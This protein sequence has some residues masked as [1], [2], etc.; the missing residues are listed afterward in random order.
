MSTLTCQN[1]GG[2][3]FEK[4]D[5]HYVCRHC[6][7]I[8]RPP[9]TMPHTKL[10]WILILSLVLVAGLFLL[11]RTLHS[12]QD[13]LSHIATAAP[14]QASLPNTT[15]S[16]EKNVTV[17]SDF[18]ALVRSRLGS[19]PIRN[20]IDVYFHSAKLHK[21]FYMAIDPDKRY[22][23]GYAF[24]KSSSKQAQTIARRYC[25]VHRAKMKLRYRCEAYLIDNTLLKGAS[26]K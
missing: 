20:I 9:E 22:A 17:E 12:I 2:S 11:Y 6:K 5:D 15:R 19:Y 21:A 16:S 24:D 26:R 14:S 1:C 3:S 18:A 4:V 7:S 25:E 23:Y 13:D 8:T 10:T